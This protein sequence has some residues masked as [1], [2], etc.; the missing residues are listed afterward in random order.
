[1]DQYKA[2][3][4]VWMLNYEMTAKKYQFAKLTHV[5]NVIP[6]LW[7]RSAKKIDIKKVGG[8]RNLSPL[9]INYTIF[10]FHLCFMII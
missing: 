6:I 7:G 2:E 10:I 9:I 5:H 3:F 8:S 4:K 1:M